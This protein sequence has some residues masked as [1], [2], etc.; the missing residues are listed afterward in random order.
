MTL[1]RLLVV[2]LLCAPLAFGQDPPTPFARE[3]WNCRKDA[4]PLLIVGLYHMNNPGQDRFGAT[5]GDVMGEA[6]QKEIGLLR[7]RLAAFAPTKIAVEAPFK[8]GNTARDFEQFVAGRYVLTPNEIDQVGFVLAKRLGHKTVFPVDFPMWMDGRVPAEIGV[9]KPRPAG[10]GATSE[11]PPTEA[12]AIY[13]ELQK[14]IAEESVLEVLRYVNSWDY[15]RQDGGLY[16]DNLRPDPYSGDLYE[17]S[18]ALTNWY[19]RNA[20]IFTNLYR[21]VEP[22]DRVL[23][24]IG[25]GHNAILRQFAIDSGDFCLVDTLSYL[26]P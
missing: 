5:V 22:G 13:R 17:T 3:D 18:N 25:S 11:E 14:R 24:L 1:P 15:T 9:A 6:K 7:D 16:V 2:A 20:R 10:T 19:K 8:G 4:M 23:L 26:S 12:P 21:I